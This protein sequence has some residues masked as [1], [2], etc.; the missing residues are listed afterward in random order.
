MYKVSGIYLHIFQLKGTIIQ[1]KSNPDIKLRESR[2][3][4]LKKMPDNEEDQ[5]SDVAGSSTMS[6]GYK[7][8]APPRTHEPK[9]RE[10]VIKKNTRDSIDIYI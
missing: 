10:E 7:P 3:Y 1:E 5:E 2:E 8:A 6:P 9:I 4:S